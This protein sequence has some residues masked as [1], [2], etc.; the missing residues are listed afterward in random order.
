VDLTGRRFGVWGMGSNRYGVHNTH[1]FLPPDLP[2]L[3]RYW[4]PQ[5]A[6]SAHAHTHTP[7]TT[8]P[9][10]RTSASTRFSFVLFQRWY[11]PYI[12]H[13]RGQTGPTD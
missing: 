1:T 2:L 11:N 6:T 4:I 10:P 3:R 5:T 9:A 13:S 8:L 12:P 7:P